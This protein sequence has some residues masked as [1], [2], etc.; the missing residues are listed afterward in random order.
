ME[1]ALGR[2]LFA[3]KLS[4][5]TCVRRRSPN[6]KNLALQEIFVR[7]DSMIR[8]SRKQHCA[9]GAN[10]ISQESQHAVKRKVQVKLIKRAVHKDHVSGLQTEIVGQDFSEAP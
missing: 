6:I 3:R 2:R 8:V 1:T 5:Q 9:A 7:R 4:Q 10:Y